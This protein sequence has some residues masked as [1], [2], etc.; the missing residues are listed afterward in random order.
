MGGARQQVGHEV[1]RTVSKGTQHGWSKLVGSVGGHVQENSGMESADE[2]LCAARRFW[3]MERGCFVI[4]F[5]T[6]GW[7][8]RC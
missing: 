4:I 5:L 3:K 6:I 2:I 7:E 8:N 1:I